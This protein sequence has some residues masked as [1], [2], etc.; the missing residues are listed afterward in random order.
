MGT[1][2]AAPQIGVRR[3]PVSRPGDEIRRPG[4]RRC[5]RRSRSRGSSRSRWCCRR[6]DWNGLG[7]AE[8]AAWRRLDQ[9]SRCEVIAKAWCVDIPFDRPGERDGLAASV[10][11]RAGNRVLVR[12][13]AGFEGPNG[14]AGVRLFHSGTRSMLYLRP[15][16]WIQLSAQ[17]C[18]HKS[19]LSIGRRSCAAGTGDHARRASLYVPSRPSVAV[20]QSSLSSTAVADL[21]HS[22]QILYGVSREGP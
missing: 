21:P 4:R 2:V 9:W 10:T 7:G 11:M 8:G 13:G 12:F 5:G 17:A 22:W 18:G 14:F 20:S 6:V 19:E 15:F 1:S 3:I 16:N